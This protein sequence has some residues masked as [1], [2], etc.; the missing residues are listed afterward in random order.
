MAIQQNPTVS[1]RIPQP[2]RELMAKRLN[3]HISEG[4]FIRDAI[5]EKIERDSP[6]LYEA[7]FKMEKGASHTM[8]GKGQ[9]RGPPSRVPAGGSP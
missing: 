2:L 6:E 1:A 8:R 7:M 5:R 3:A 4:D 9:P